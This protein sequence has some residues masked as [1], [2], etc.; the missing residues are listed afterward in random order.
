M[1]HHKIEIPENLEYKFDFPAKL[2]KLLYIL[3]GIGL[4]LIILGLLLPSGGHGAEHAAEGA[5]GGG[6]EV[7]FAAR[8]FGNWLVNAFMFAS[9]GAV[10]LFFVAVQ[11]VSNGYWYVLLKRIMESIGQYVI[12]G[13]V[14]LL[15]ALGGIKV[16]YHWAHPE[17]VEH[18]LILQAKEAYL[19][20]PF[21]IIRA[22]IVFA[23]W[24]FFAIQFKKL[25]LLEDK[26]WSVANFNKSMKYAGIYV[27]LFAV[28][29]SIASW[30]WIM[31]VNPHWFSTMFAVYTFSSAFV[32]TLA[33]IT[34]IAIYLYKNNY[35]PLLN[36]SHFHDLGK[37]VFGFSVFWAYI[38]FSQFMLIW[39]ANIPEETQWFVPMFEHYKFLFFVNLFVNFFFPFLALMTNSSKRNLLWL[40]VVSGVIIVGHWLDFFLMVIPNLTQGAVGV[41]FFEIGMFLVFVSIFFF[42]VFQQLA[43]VSLVPQKHPYVE[44]SIAHH[45]DI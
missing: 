41:G 36:M 40:G 43:K 39:Y 37:F 14:T 7:G 27:V 9:I 15:I 13:A 21:F 12:V 16:L 44:E 3:G 8:F 38:W 34:L 25:S 18:D 10:G 5:H 33:I 11:I 20:I 1:A 42:F 6:H 17:V 24:I 31:S 28:S 4:V 23:L 45:Y 30:D 32:T 26:Q 22:L 35:L 29:Y 2:K 19:N